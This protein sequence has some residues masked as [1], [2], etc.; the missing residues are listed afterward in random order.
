MIVLII[1]SLQGPQYPPLEYNL[2]GILVI[3]GFWS[4]SAVEFWSSTNADQ[5]SCQLSDYPRGMSQGPTVSR[6][7]QL[8]SLEASLVR[9]SAFYKRSSKTLGAMFLKNIVQ[10]IA[11]L[12]KKCDVLGFRKP[13][14]RQRA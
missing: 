14:Q 7:G 3:G 1:V 8:T 4:P 12:S 2:A 11:S 10:N 5:E 6:G 9:C 13:T